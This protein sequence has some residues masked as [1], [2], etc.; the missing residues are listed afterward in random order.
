MKEPGSNRI[1]SI[2]SMIVFEC[3]ARHGNFTKAASELHTSQPAVSLHISRLESQISARLFDRSRSG[4]TL[5]EAGR[6]FL[7][8][9]EV[10]LGALHTA[11]EE[12]ANLSPANQVVIACGHDTSHFVVF[13]RYDEL[14][15][16][17]GRE[18]RLRLLTF[19][20]FPRDPPYDP[21]ADIVLTW[22]AAG[23]K[24]NVAEEDRALVFEEEV[25]LVC[26]PGFAAAH[27]EMLKRP[28]TE[29]EGLTFLS[30]NLPNLGWATWSDW[31][32]VAGYPLATPFYEGFDSYIQILEAAAAGLGVALGWRGYIERHLASEAIVTL[33]EG[34][35]AFD[36]RFDALLTAKGRRNPLARNC[37]S[38]F[39]R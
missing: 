1:P 18:N 9:V 11:M 39:A 26:S 31:F 23:A 30:L 29:W 20:R 34:F 24:Q 16:A 17:V 33:D 8:A 15:D 6:H 37:L 2:A 10:A 25:Q 22:N 28:I 21:A 32:E 4:V 12:A 14:W 5:T 3:A 36:G 13:P 19:Q 7:D 38:F 35:V 27:A